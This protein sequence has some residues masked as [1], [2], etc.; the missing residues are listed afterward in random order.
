M[1]Y[2]LKKA[3]L[4]RAFISD[5]ENF[6]MK[7]KK[8]NV[9]RNTLYTSAASFLVISPQQCRRLKITQTL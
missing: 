7:F 6:V 4:S 2:L 8:K 1:S 3:R 9:T 5:A